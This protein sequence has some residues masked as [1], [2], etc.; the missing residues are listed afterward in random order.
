MR[1]QDFARIEKAIAYIQDHAQEQPDLAQ[2]AAAVH[3][4][5]YSFQRLFRR[6]A[7]VSPKRFLQYLTAQ[8][9]R[10][11]LQRSRPVL[12]AAFEA[13]LSSPGRLHDL[14]LN[15]YAMTPGQVASRGQG[16]VIRHG[17]HPSPFGPC[18]LLL[19]ERGVCGL[20]FVRH[21]EEAQALEYLAG[22]W[23][24][25]ALRPDQAATRPVVQR[26]FA[27]AAQGQGQPLNLLVRG[28]NFQIQVWEALLRIPAGAAA[29]YGELARWLGRPDAARAV[30][31]CCGANPIAYLIPCH[32]VLRGSGALGGYRWGLERKRA[33]LAWEAA[34]AAG[35]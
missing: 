21:G 16:L 13:E 34:R 26:I 28:S 8:Y 12:Q 4:S 33:L 14:T 6:F 30:G 35:G 23:P 25:A 10:E 29:T 19:T 15:V 24:E 3:L 31:T 27:P 32:R 7:G 1:A 9:A 18:L 17:L 22:R 5:E 2:I 11:L 20:A